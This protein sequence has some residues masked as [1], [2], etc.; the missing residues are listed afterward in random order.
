MNPENVK[1]TGDY[2]T[3]KR[4]RRALAPFFAPT[5]IQKVEPLIKHNISQ[6]CTLLS[7][8]RNSQEPVLLSHLY[9]CMTADIIT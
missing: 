7:E 1:H 6:L 8:A 5:A 2:E 3:H 4:R 9:R